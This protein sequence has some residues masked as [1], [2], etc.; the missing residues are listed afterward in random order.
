MREYQ[1]YFTFYFEIET[2]LKENVPT[3]KHRLENKNR[4]AS[5]YMVRWS[6]MGSLAGWLADNHAIAFQYVVRYRIV[7][8]P[9]QRK[10]IYGFWA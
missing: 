7:F 9:L 4:F 6:G 10:L 3:N 1:Q 2:A 5:L 8:A